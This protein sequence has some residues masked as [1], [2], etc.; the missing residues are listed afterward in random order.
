MYCS[1]PIFDT[2]DHCYV[3]PL[4][5]KIFHETIPNNLESL[6]SLKSFLSRY[7]LFAHKRRFIS[8]MRIYDYVRK[9]SSE[10][11]IWNNLEQSPLRILC[12][13]SH[14]GIMLVRCHTGLTSYPLAKDSASIWRQRE[15]QHRYPK[16]MPE[17]R[18]FFH[19]RFPIKTN[20][21]KPAYFSVFAKIYEG[22][23]RLRSVDAERGKER[24]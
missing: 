7:F 8:I 21:P 1:F 13:T 11:R 24:V 2:C 14:S 18:S 12:T 16:V 15:F 20:C 9:I 19:S 5:G 17:W 10:W 4:E 6:N 3:I 22:R 23:L